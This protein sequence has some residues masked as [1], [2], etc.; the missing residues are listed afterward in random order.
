MNLIPRVSGV[1]DHYAESDEHAL[2]I[3]RTI[4]KNLNR[5][6]SKFLTE[7][8]YDEPLYS[9]DDMTGIIP[10][11]SKKPFDIRKVTS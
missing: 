7:N 9:S 6:K 2:Q 3:A 5:P 10:A 11:D 1:T 8:S 4:V